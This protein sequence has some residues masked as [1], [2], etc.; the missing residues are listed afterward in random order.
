MQNTTIDY[1]ADNWE[2]IADII[3]QET[4]ETETKETKETK[5]VSGLREG[6]RSI[7]S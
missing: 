5:E 4:K 1:F 7:Y 3:D 2:D 6:K